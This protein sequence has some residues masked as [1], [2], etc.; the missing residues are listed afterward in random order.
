MDESQSINEQHTA[1]NNNNNNANNN[2]DDDNAMDENNADPIA[3]IGGDRL[4]IL[5]EVSRRGYHC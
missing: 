5:Q 1:N 4:A 2:D 3:A